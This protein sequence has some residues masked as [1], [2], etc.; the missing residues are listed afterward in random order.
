[1]VA[2][3]A[4]FEGYRTY[5]KFLAFI[6]ACSAA[7]PLSIIAAVSAGM[8]LHVSSSSPLNLLF[9]L[10]IGGGV[11]A[12]IVLVSGLLLFDSMTMSRKALGTALICSI[13]GGFLGLLGGEIDRELGSAINNRQAGPFI[14]WQAG[15]ALML[16]VLLRRRKSTA[17]TSA[18][19]ASQQKYPSDP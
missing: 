15:I 6:C 2:Y 16:G 3:F 13:G 14:L 1:M 7:Y 10:F 5:L 9:Y 18:Q 4:L 19:P 8:L 11:G 12:C 17:T